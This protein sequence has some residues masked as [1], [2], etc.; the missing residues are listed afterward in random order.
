MKRQSYNPKDIEPTIEKLRMLMPYWIS[1]DNQRIQ[2][3]EE[4]L[5]KIDDMGLKEVACELKETN[6][7]IENRQIRRWKKIVPQDRERYPGE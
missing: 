5:R 1:R 7:H 4:W 2:D 6:R 3:S